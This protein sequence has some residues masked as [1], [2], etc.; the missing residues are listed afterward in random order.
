GAREPAREP[1]IARRHEPRGD[2]DPPGNYRDRENAAEWSEE[3]SE[4]GEEHRRAARSPRQDVA[5]PRREPIREGEPC[6]DHHGSR[7]DDGVSSETLEALVGER[8]DQEADRGPHEELWLREEGERREQ[9]G[10]AS[11][12]DRR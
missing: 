11:C 9:I 2:D 6:A 1:R 7:E 10:R 12:R 3:L 8:R 5:R 4:C